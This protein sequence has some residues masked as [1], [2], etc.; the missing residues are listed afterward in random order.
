[1]KGGKR[2]LG[3]AVKFESEQRECQKK[4]TVVHAGRPAWGGQTAQTYAPPASTSAARAGDVPA[5]NVRL[6]FEGG[7]SGAG[8]R[9]QDYLPQQLEGVEDSLG[10]S[11]PTTGGGGVLRTH[12]TRR[13]VPRAPREVEGPARGPEPAPATRAVAVCGDS[14]TPSHSPLASVL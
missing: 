8:W 12:L 3:G 10:P 5:C 13:A 1:M 7:R 9:G 11:S 2:H 14:S 4:Y 6:C